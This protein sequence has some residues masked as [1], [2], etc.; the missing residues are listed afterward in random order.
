[1]EVEGSRHANI[2]FCGDDDLGYDRSRT[3]VAA[4]QGLQLDE[5]YRL[6]HLPLIAPEHPDAIAARD[7]ASYVRGRH[8]KVYSLV[9]PIPWP[10]LSASSAFRELEGDLRASLFASKI[11]W[12]VMEQRRDRLHA[13]ICGSLSVGQD[14]PPQITKAQRRELADL[15]PI[16]VELRGLFSGSVNIGRTP[17][18]GTQIICFGGSSACWAGARRTCTSWVSITSLTI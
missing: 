5:A 12:E 10:A 18:A 4:G 2:Q 7:G 8:P 9:L 15:G 14:T 11:A 17:S 3:R 16:H 13:T 6:A 1:M